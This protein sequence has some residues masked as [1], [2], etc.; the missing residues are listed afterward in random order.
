MRDNPI[1][2]L[3]RGVAFASIAAL[4]G[5]CGGEDGTRPERPLPLPGSGVEDPG[6]GPFDCDQAV[7][8]EVQ[9]I[10]DFENGAA[11]RSWYTNNDVCELCQDLID[12]RVGPYDRGA[13]LERAE[14]AV[15]DFG[16]DPSDD[17]L[18][19]AAREQLQRVY[20][21]LGRLRN[22]LKHEHLWREYADWQDTLVRGMKTLETE[23]RREDL[24][25]FLQ[26]R[27]AWAIQAS[28]DCRPGCEASQI[29][30]PVFAKPVPATWIQGDGRCGSRYALRVISGPL[31]DWGMTIGTRFAPPLD[32]NEWEGIAFWARVG[33]LTDPE[34]GQ[35]IGRATVRF[36]VG[37]RHTHEKFDEGE[38]PICNPDHTDDTTE[39]GCDKFGISLV[40]GP[41]WELIKLPFDE[42]R[43]KGWGKQAPYFDKAAVHSGSFQFDRGT[44]DVWID[45]MVLYRRQQP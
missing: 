17:A 5:A 14:V 31:L 39:T 24:Q 4:L 20:D 2:T 25:R 33:P 40:L 6:S 10:E 42:L 26:E 16:R 35:A 15:A 19:E 9:G 22:N 29:P 44:W 23:E 45:D 38:G 28:A 13:S 30:T 18:Q 34:T 7:G 3:L 41:D 27:I 36:E 8:L 11:G 21:E 1:R 37:E 12:L 43:Q 32:G